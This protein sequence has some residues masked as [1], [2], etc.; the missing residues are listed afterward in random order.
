MAL[1]EKSREN[2]GVSKFEEEVRKTIIKVDQKMN[3][4]DKPTYT[5]GLPF[6][7]SMAK[8]FPL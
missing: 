1:D 6:Y 2:K 8:Q 3:K 4:N 5:V 7:Q